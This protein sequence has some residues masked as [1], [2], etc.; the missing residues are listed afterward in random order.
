MRKVSNTDSGLILRKSRSYYIW[1]Y[2]IYRLFNVSGSLN[3]LSWAESP[4]LI[5]VK[6][7]SI[8]RMFFFLLVHALYS[9]PQINPCVGMCGG[10]SPLLCF[11][12]FHT[13]LPQTLAWSDWRD[14]HWNQKKF[15]LSS[16]VLSRAPVNLTVVVLRAVS[17]D[18]ILP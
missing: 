14:C 11:R 1:L 13:D 10:C 4:G 16:Q 3:P 7:F 5:V 12:S 6:Q 8:L 15:L 9:L 18:Y 2:F 17:P